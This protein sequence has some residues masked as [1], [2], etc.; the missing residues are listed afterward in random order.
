MPGVKYSAYYKRIAGYPE[1]ARF[2]R[3][4]EEWSW[5]LYRH[6]AEINRLKEECNACIRKLG[7]GE[8]TVTDLQSTQIE[9]DSELNQKVQ[10]LDRELVEYSM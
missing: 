2:R 8:V 9:Q 1:L 7:L 3:Y 5:R 6:S 4:P 10:M